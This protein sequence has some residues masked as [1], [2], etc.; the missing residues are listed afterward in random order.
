MVIKKQVTSVIDIFSYP[1]VAGILTACGYAIRESCS[2]SHALHELG[3]EICW[4]NEE[5]LFNTEFEDVADD[6]DLALLASLC[7]AKLAQLATER[8]RVKV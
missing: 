8:T 7:A 1:D 6:V 5:N 4:L 2:L 3:F